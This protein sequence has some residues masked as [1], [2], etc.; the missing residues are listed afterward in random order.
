MPQY[1]VSIESSFRL[2][3]FISLFVF[4]ALIEVWKP[5]RQTSNIRN[6]RWFSHIG[7]SIVNSILLRIIFPSTAVGI[8]WWIDEHGFGLLKLIDL[9][10]W[11]EI[12]WAIVILDLVIYLQHR[13]FHTVPILW[14]LHR[15]HHTD[16]HFDVTTG[17]RFHP[18]EILLSMLIKIITILLLGPATLAVFIF[19]IILSSISLFNHGNIQIHKKIEKWLRY[20]IV[21][22]DIHRIH[23]SIQHQ[24]TNSNFGFNLPIWD[25]IF[26]TYRAQ[27]TFD[28]QSMN[29]GLI[30]FRDTKET[31]IDQLLTQ[32]FRNS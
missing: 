9:P 30:E 14:R 1:I 32:P 16:I 29:I 28:H 2:I 21:T 23:H 18:I 3:V 25:K 7:I 4:I 20:V 17:F 13:I 26:G 31:R 5:V 15:M 8:A 11:L 19:E 6:K 24:E 10:Q 12:I 27:P 22:P